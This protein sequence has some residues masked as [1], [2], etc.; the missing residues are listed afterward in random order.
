MASFD[1][2]DFY[3]VLQVDP[4]A[5]PEVIRSAYRTLLRV[6]GKHPDL[7]GDSSEART[8]IAA[9]GTL[10]DARRR[11]AYDQ[12]LRAHSIA[13]APAPPPVVAPAPPA[14]AAPPSSPS[15][16]WIRAAL[17]EYR[18]A[19][20]APFARSFDLV[21]ERPSLTAPRVYAKAYS[22]ITREQWPAILLLCEAIR[23]ARHGLLPSSDTVL[24]AAGRVDDLA[25]LLAASRRHAAPW[26]W[27]RT[28]ISICTFDPPRLHRGR[29]FPPKVLRRIEAGLRGF[30]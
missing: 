5:H 16:N 14:P 23:V 29:I 30:A 18:F 27:S 8:I 25:A 22:T 21:L 1:R 17:P 3:K 26:S 2:P 20:R 7:G 19:F 11:E 24:L 28:V 6:L 10:S 9:Y 4:S 12:W 13:A 15:L